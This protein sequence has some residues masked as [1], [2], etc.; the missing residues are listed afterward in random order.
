MMSQK[1]EAK[2]KSSGKRDLMLLGVSAK[3]V[4][5]GRLLLMTLE[6]RYQ[7]TSDVNTE[8]IYT[9]PM[10]FGAVLME[11]HVD[12]NG[13]V[14]KGEVAAKSLA[15]AKYEEALL[16]GNT[17]IMLERGADGSYTLELG[18]LL[19]Y[20]EC[21]IMVR[22]AQVLATEHGQV[23]M[24]LPTTLAPRYGNPITQGRKQPHQVP[25]TNLTAHYPFDITVTL[26]GEMAQTSVSCLSHITSCHRNDE[27][28]EIKLSQLGS[29][30]RDFILVIDGIKN[31]SDALISRDRYVEGQSAV[32]A[33]FS[34]SFKTSKPNPLCAKVLVDCSGSMSGDSMDAAKLALAAIV[35][36][37][38]PEDRISLSR[39]GSSIEHRSRSLWR[40]TEPAKASARRWVET[41][42]ADLGGTEMEAA[43]T[44]TLSI[45]HEGSCDILLITD[46]EIEGIDAVIDVA[47]QSGQRVF[48]VGIGAS[49]AEGHLRRLATATGGHCDFVAPGEDVAPA[50]VR[51][52]DRMHSARASG[53]RVQWPQSLQLNWEQKVQS[54]AFES[55]AFTV[56]AFVA[57]P[58]EFCEPSTVKLFGRIDD[59]SEEVLMGE[60][61]LQYTESTINTLA[62]MTGFAQIQEL[63]A[64]S[65]D[66]AVLL[67]Q[68]IAVRYQLVTDATNFI[69][70]H[71]RANGEK[72]EE[73]PELHK[74]EQMQA[75]GWGGV[76]SVK[77]SA[78]SNSAR[79]P[80]RIL[81]SATSNVPIS[82]S[83]IAPSVWR[84]SNTNA[85]KVCSQLDAGGLD[86]YEMPAFLRNQA[87]S[88]KS[89]RSIKALTRQGVDQENPL[90]WSKKIS[91]EDAAG[92]TYVGITPAGMVQ[93]LRLNHESFWPD[94]YLGLRELGVG[95]TVC[96]WLEFEVGH[97]REE[98]EVV[99]AFLT[100]LQ[101]TKLPAYPSVQGAIE[102]IKQVF[103]QQKA[104]KPKDGTFADICSEISLAFANCTARR[105]PKAVV[106]FPEEARA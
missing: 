105:W 39:F 45:P 46:G 95:L 80:S 85:S 64:A 103:T 99:H 28:L 62:R 43:L 19:A 90:Y 49:P 27:G 17:S 34:P 22:Y 6:Q 69:L 41:L 3:G 44:S 48:V 63:Q 11:V 4:I 40:G 23:R 78:K 71:E 18:N 74:V 101:E 65:Q 30:D 55:D 84:S 83:D 15:R 60:A 75:A 12:L 52:S 13:K 86:D 56:A 10:P 106:S 59:Q 29:L 76:G 31:E 104:P 70:V 5:N 73:M 96:E 102:V 54:Y 88:H 79:G 98:I 16:E 35:E 89:V 77:F 51:M 93:W 2:M 14:L 36:S 47:M 8:I 67:G 9:F 97:G 21:Q 20:E 1:I 42:Q 7:N 91:A 61:T 94:T 26:M 38:G 66:Q 53:L 72:A 37:V 82:C 50:V 100:V 24:M 68:Q 32:M 92:H 33:F 57:T 81:R 58:F 25:V 87:D